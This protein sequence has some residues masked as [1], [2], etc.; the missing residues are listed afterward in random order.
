MVHLMRLPPLARRVGRGSH[1][2]VGAH[3]G[4]GATLPKTGVRKDTSVA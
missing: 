3:G 1:P 2:R 4:T